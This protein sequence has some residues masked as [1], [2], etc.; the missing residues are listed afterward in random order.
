[1]GIFTGRTVDS[2]KEKLREPLRENPR[3]FIFLLTRA[4]RLDGILRRG[5]PTVLCFPSV[6]NRHSHV[7]MLRARSTNY[8]SVSSRAAFYG[9]HGRL[10]EGIKRCPS[11]R[12]RGDNDRE[13]W[14]GELAFRS[15]HGISSI[16]NEMLLERYVSPMKIVITLSLVRQTDKRLIIKADFVR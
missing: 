2:R 16:M 9:I 11:L 13:R 6:L 12:E 1:M 4:P 7:R 15:N 10:L 3:V 5:I 14:A 8:L